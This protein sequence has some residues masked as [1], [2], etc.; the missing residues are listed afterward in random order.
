M[1]SMILHFVRFLD[2]EI[3]TNIELKCK[4]VLD[5]LMVIVVNEN[6]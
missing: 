2:K 1:Y 6:G 3:G 4:Y 5:K